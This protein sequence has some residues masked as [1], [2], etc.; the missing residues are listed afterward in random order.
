MR[1][2]G[3]CLTG[4]TAPPSPRPSPKPSPK[5]SPSRWLRTSPRRS[6]PSAH[7]PRQP[8]PPRGVGRALL[9]ERR[10]VAKPQWS[11]SWAIHAPASS[12]DRILT[13]VLF[14]DVFRGHRH[15]PEAEI[16]QTLLQLLDPLL[17]LAEH[18]EQLF[19]TLAETEAH[20]ERDS[21]EKAVD[22]GHA[23][24]S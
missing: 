1:M 5:P 2:G 6:E 14:I 19:H 16:S 18:Q 24:T 17:V 10:R 11:R 15:R 20:G 8:P 3:R 21:D 12:V 23:A 4:P 7:A 13:A 22:K 9:R